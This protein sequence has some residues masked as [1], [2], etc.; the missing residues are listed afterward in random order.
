[1]LV[2]LRELAIDVQLLTE[3]TCWTL[4]LSVRGGFHRIVRNSW[5]EPWGE[6]GMFRIVTSAYKGGRG[7]DYNLALE[8]ACGFG[9]PG[10]WQNAED[11]DVGA[12]ALREATFAA[13]NLAKV[14]AS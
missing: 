14:V 12:T 9:V 5:G 6:R 2:A 8:S 4:R 11:L 1:M 10:T 7:N 13:V 3:G